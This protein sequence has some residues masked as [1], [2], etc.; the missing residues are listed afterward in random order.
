MEIEEDDADYKKI[1]MKDVV[2]IFNI[3]KLSKKDA[4]V[5]EVKLKDA[6]GKDKSMFNLTEAGYQTVLNELFRVIANSSTE[7]SVK[8][9]EHGIV[10]YSLITYHMEDLQVGWLHK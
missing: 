9:T 10:L 6:R 7:I 8:S 4:G 1:E 5:Y 2:L 3:G